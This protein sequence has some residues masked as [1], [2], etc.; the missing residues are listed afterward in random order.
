MQKQLQVYLEIIWWIVTF[1]V[2]YLVMKPIFD[3]LSMDYSF[4][5]WNVAY[6]VFFITYTRYAFLLKHTFIANWTKFKV[7]LFFST[8]PYLFLGIESVTNFKSYWDNEGLTEVTSLLQYPLSELE[9]GDLFDY[10]KTETMLFGIG[11]LMAG[12]LMAL[13]M[14]VSFW[15]QK[16]TADSI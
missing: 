6:I 5:W 9:K 16:N 7:F 14:A 3:N 12:V 15:R 2:V 4:F 10:I 8:V 11:A 13:R 1:I